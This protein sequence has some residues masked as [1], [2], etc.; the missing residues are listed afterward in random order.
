MESVARTTWSN[1]F[2]WILLGCALILEESSSHKLTLKIKA[3]C[4]LVRWLAFV[5]R[6]YTSSEMMFCRA[7]SNRITVRAAMTFLKDDWLASTAFWIETNTCR[8]LASHAS[9]AMRTK[10]DAL[11]FLATRAAYVAYRKRSPANFLLALD[12]L[13]KLQKKITMSW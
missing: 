8:L 13:H 9:G 5:S 7:C 12:A 1:K 4:G 3:A 11:T 10:P 6:C 2:L